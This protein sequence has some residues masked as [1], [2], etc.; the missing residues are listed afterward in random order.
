MSDVNVEVKPGATD[1]PATPPS[2]LTALVTALVESNQLLIVKVGEM[3][4]ELAVLRER[5]YVAQ[6]AANRA[7]SAA[8]NAEVVANTAANI[9]LE[10]AV[11]TALVTE[12]E[13]EEEEE[14]DEDLGESAEVVEI[15]EETPTPETPAQIVEQAPEI[16]IERKKRYFV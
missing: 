2:D 1:A 6:E 4:G 12:A 9:A 8:E 16:R 5:A 3:A 10:T 14:E 7:E 11:E 15:V 13:E